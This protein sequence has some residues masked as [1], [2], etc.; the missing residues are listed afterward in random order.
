MAL[1]SVGGRWRM[2]G[3]S[4]SNEIGRPTSSSGVSGTLCRMPSAAVCSVSRTSGM[5]RT[6]ADGTP[7][8]RLKGAVRAFA[9]EA[10]LALGVAQEIHPLSGAG[11]AAAAGASIGPGNEVD[12]SVQGMTGFQH[13]VGFPDAVAAGRI[14][15]QRGFFGEVR[16]VKADVILFAGIAAVGV[17]VQQ[18][19]LGDLA[20]GLKVV[21]AVEGEDRLAFFV[22]ANPQH[23]GVPGEVGFGQREQ[24]APAVGGVMDRGDGRQRR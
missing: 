19:P 1:P 21:G 12:F 16:S 9:D 4:P 20:F 14:D 15:V 3:R 6:G 11:I 8:A 5:V 22:L 13:G 7:A 17:V 18:N 24:L 23:V 10:P 2:A